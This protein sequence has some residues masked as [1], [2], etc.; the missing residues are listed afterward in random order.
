[1]KKRLLVLLLSI[2]PFFLTGCWSYL[3]VDEITIVTGLAIDKDEN[4]NYKLTFEVIDL[5]KSNKETGIAVSQ[6]TS[7]GETILEAVRDARRT[8][9]SKLYFSH[10]QIIIVNSE[11]AQNEGLNAIMNFFIR[12]ENVRETIKVVIS[13]EE[14]AASLLNAKG[15][16]NSI[17]SY[18]MLEII[19]DVEDSNLYSTEVQLYEIIN[20]LNGEGME[21]ILPV[22][23]KVQVEENEYVSLSG[24]AAF[25]KDKMHSFLTAE[26]TKYLLF[27]L[28]K[29][30]GGV[31]NVNMEDESNLVIEIYKNK[32]KIDYEYKNDMLKFFLD[33]NMQCL[34]REI[35][36][37][38]Q[39]IDGEWIQQTEKLIEQ[40]LKNEIEK[41]I[42]KIQEEG[43]YDILRFGNKIYKTEPKLWE[44]LKKDWDKKFSTIEVEVNPKVIIKNT[45]FTK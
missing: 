21:L 9:S 3:G 40:F 45:S 2:F 17:I 5:T 20:I 16:T 26:E 8:S 35:T 27:A 1:M 14:N 44:N 42:K 4:E 37:Q 10:T 32:T 25:N 11:I 23:K 18:K 38:K 41:S 28:D 12:D 19:E 36:N 29:V 6:V 34:V 24:T 22:F 7:N 31:L 39:K 13:G 15:I 30:E 43:I 33:I